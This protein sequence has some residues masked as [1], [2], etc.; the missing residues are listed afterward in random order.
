VYA[1]ALPTAIAA[2]ETKTAGN[3]HDSKS[4]GSAVSESSRDATTETPHNN[5][6]NKKHKDP[7]LLPFP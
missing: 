5:D 1:S 6:D 3:D 4:K 7:F 2:E